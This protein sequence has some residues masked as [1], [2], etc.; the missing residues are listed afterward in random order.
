MRQ[1]ISKFSRAIRLPLWWQHIVAPILGTVYLILWWKPPSMEIIFITIPLFIISILGTASF[2]YWLNDW[3]DRE[4]DQVALKPNATQGTSRLQRWLILFLLLSLAVLPWYFLPQNC[5]SINSWLAL[6]VAL[7]LYSVPPFRFK[8]RSLMGPLCDMAYGH[9]LPIWITIGVFYPILPF[10]PLSSSVLAISLSL[11][12]IAKGLRNIIQHQLED[13]RKDRIARLHTFVHQLGAFRSALA[14]SFLLL[15]LELIFLSITLFLI[16]PLL[17]LFLLFY[18]WTYG[19]RIWS[20]K[21]SKAG[22]IRLTFRSWFVLNDFYEASLPLFSIILLI[23]QHW[24]YIFLLFLH[25]ILFPKS[26][27]HWSWVW[28][29]WEAIPLW[30]FLQRYF[31]ML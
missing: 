7:V 31:W 3:T 5:L 13:R 12:L 21:H 2:G 23:G 9:L 24:A 30:R 28:K 26:L 29:K 8:T 19:A 17:L 4:Q 11:T 22:G 27:N 1:P 10:E 15:P 6:I 14:I 25:L 20:W 16:S 18:L